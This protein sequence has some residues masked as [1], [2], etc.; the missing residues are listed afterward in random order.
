MIIDSRAPTRIDLAGGTLDIWPIYLFLNPALTLNLGIDLY[1]QARIQLNES[2]GI[3]L[4]SEDQNLSVQLNWEDLQKDSSKIP[5]SLELHFKLL[6]Y[7]ST[8][9]PSK[10]SCSL[11]LS[12]HARSPARAGLGGSSALNIAMMGALLAWVQGE[13]LH[14]DQEALI[15]IARDMETTVIQVPA[16]LQDYYGALFGGLQSLRWQA[17]KN[18][19]AS[20][21]LSTLEGLEQRILL[22]YSGQS[23]NSGINNWAL[24]KSFIDREPKIRS[25]F[26]EIAD[27]TLQL[28]F[29]L[30][31]Q[32]WIAAGSAILEEWKTRKTLS[33]GITTPEMDKAFQVAL[34]EGASAFKVCGAGGGGCF[35]IYFNTPDP[36]LKK[37]VQAKISQI[38]TI[39]PLPFHAAPKGLEVKVGR[40]S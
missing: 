11:I 23:R 38:Q 12:T 6:K 4:K 8:L 24:F 22:F 19:R 37:R 13:P 32:D 30:K 15:E 35:F 17:G 2:N 34:Q 9:H 16:G 18:Q 3:I 14:I 31:K 10:K 21:P 25:Q 36:E 40:V 5:P 1:A 7:F 26:E 28:E 20:L 29:A 33:S 27:A 39:R